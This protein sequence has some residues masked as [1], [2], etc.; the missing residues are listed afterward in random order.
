[1]NVM[2]EIDTFDRNGKIN[3]YSVVVD[4]VKF[5]T[6]TSDDEG[7]VL[8]IAIAQ[9]HLQRTMEGKQNGKAL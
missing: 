5:C 6:T 4:N 1:M 2:M 3:V 8:G 9:L 7:L